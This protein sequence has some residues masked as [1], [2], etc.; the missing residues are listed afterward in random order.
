MGIASGQRTWRLRIDRRNYNMRIG[1][2]VQGINLGVSGSSLPTEEAHY[3]HSDGTSRVGDSPLTGGGYATSDTVEVHLDMNAHTLRFKKNGSWVD[4]A[5]PIPSG[6]CYFLF[7]NIDATDDQV[8]LV[9]A[10][11]D[12]GSA[13]GAAVEAK[14]RSAEC[15]AFLSVPSGC[16]Q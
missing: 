10:E 11:G 9:E 13:A 2:A 4:A 16:C 5:K 8:T 3:W 1:V 12:S 14:V 7:V 15:P 6:R